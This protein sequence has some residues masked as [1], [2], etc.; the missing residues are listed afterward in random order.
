VLIRALVIGLLSRGIVSRFAAG[1]K[2]LNK[3]IRKRLSRKSMPRLAPSRSAPLAL[4]Q[5]SLGALGS[6][7]PIGPKCV[8]IRQLVPEM[9]RQMSAR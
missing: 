8:A 3:M 9:W 6:M 7:I 2:P 5:S 1:P 4:D